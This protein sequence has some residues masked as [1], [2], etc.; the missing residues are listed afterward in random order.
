MTVAYLKITR[1][2]TKFLLKNI[3]GISR[4]N[5]ENWILWF[6]Q[7]QEKALRST[8]KSGAAAIRW[9]TRSTVRPGK[10]WLGAAGSVHTQ[11]W[12]W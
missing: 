10:D 1:Q 7:L 9:W 6:S 11:L 4:N 5:Q 12:D 3:T 2:P 8:L